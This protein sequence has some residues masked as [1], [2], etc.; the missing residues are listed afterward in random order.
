M[1]NKKQ[2]TLRQIRLKDKRNQK[3]MAT[4]LNISYSHYTKL[5]TSYVNPS[6]NLLKR[7]K[8]VFEWVDMNDFF[9]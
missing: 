4:L 1:T 2:T 3:E 9:K 8:E 5:E 7:I 6:F